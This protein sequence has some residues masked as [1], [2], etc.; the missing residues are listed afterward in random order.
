MEPNLVVDGVDL[1]DLTAVTA[2]LGD[3][4]GRFANQEDYA[5]VL[6]PEALYL[7]CAVLTAASTPGVA[8]TDAAELLRLAAWLRW[9]RYDAL[10]NGPE[11]DKQQADTEHESALV[12]FTVLY[13]TR[14]ELV[15]PSQ[16]KVVTALAQ[17][18]VSKTSADQDVAVADALLGLA[19]VAGDQGGGGA[20]RGTVQPGA[21]VRYGTHRPAASPDTPEPG[22]AGPVRIQPGLRGPD[23]DHSGRPRG[24]ARVACR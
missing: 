20:E 15:P 7:G 10:T 6:A 21:A 19:R 9:F 14:S 22:P 4:L 24:G 5:A 18:G 1:A 13:W 8:A 12:L 2:A 3:R 23:K 17:A 11:P 16:Q